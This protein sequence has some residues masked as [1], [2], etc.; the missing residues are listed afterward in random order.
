MTFIFLQDACNLFAV[1]NSELLRRLALLLGFK[2]PTSSNNL[3]SARTKADMLL[4][5][6]DEPLQL[7]RQALKQLD[8]SLQYQKDSLFG[9]LF[10]FGSENMN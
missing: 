10:V 7:V 5:S 6:L 9:E 3:I 4:E 2:P 1:Q 8:W